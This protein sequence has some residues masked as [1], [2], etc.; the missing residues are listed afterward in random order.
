MLSARTEAVIQRYSPR[1][2]KSSGRA[3]KI[4]ELQQAAAAIADGLS[5]NTGVSEAE[6]NTLLRDARHAVAELNDRITEAKA[7]QLASAKTARPVAGQEN[8]HLFRSATLGT[9]A[10]PIFKDAQTGQVIKTF[11]HDEPMAPT[12][13]RPD[14]GIGDLV[15]AVVTGNW[16]HLPTEI[17]AGSSGIGPAGG[18]LIPS[19]L[20]GWFIDLARPRARVMQAGA[21][22]IPM[23]H[24]N[25][26]IATVTADPQPGWKSENAWFSTSQGSYGQIV[27]TSKTLGVIVPLSLELVA[28]AANLNEL[29]TGQLTKRMGLMLD[30]AAIFGT[31]TVDAPKGILANTGVGNV[32]VGAKPTSYAPFNSAIGLCLAANA[33]LDGLSVLMNSDVSTLLNGLTDT[34]GQPLRPPATYQA[35]RERGAEYIANSMAS[36]GS[37]FA[38]VG[39]FSNVVIGMQQDM[40]LEIS[41]EGTYQNADASVGS[42]FGQG[43][44]L[45]RAY[46]M[47]D[48]AVQRPNFFAQ[49][50]DIRFA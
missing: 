12:S 44:I 47:V 3:P 6:W 36:S 1:F 30:A 31:G 2:Q 21:L 10:A 49:V 37:S 34:L 11:R 29:V 35:I 28:S 40:M 45:I 15:K 25:L 13:V 18:F 27:L 9:A 22:T 14:Y 42:A 41:R 26:S 33:E 43:Q 24:G 5:E 46:M 50:S 16:R 17:R 20:A 19:E 32:V 7:A 39:D 4:T 23:T 48:V 8:A 38:L